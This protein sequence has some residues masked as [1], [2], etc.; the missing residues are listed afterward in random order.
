MTADRLKTDKGPAGRTLIERLVGKIN[1][2][3]ANARLDRAP[4]LAPKVDAN[5]VQIDIQKLHKNGLL[6]PGATPSPTSEAFRILKRH[7][8]LKAFG[9]RTSPAQDRG[10]IVVLSSPLANEGKTYCALNL[11]LSLSGERDIE[12]L[13]VD[14]DCIKPEVL[15]RLGVGASR[16]LM[17]A[18]SQGTPPEDLILKTS[19]PTLFLLPAGP[20]SHDDAELLG[21]AEMRAFIQRQLTAHPNRIILFD[22]APALVASSS[23]VLAAYSGQVILVVRADFT[24]ADQLAAA[25]RLFPADAGLQLLLNRAS[26]QASRQRYGAYYGYRS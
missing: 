7:V 13:L 11:A 5:G 24:R 18:L 21:A 8:L 12:V 9:S 17:D 20:R 2:A 15:S 16:G 3:P 26:F 6:V 14:A 25:V 10:R 1:P 22:T 19:I 23:P 4:A